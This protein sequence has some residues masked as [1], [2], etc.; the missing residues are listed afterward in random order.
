VID[1]HHYE[2]MC[3]DPGAHRP[4]LLAL[5][6][7]IAERYRDRPDR[8]FF[9][10]LNEPNGKLTDERW[11][12]LIPEL[13]R[14]VRASNPRRAVIV[15]PGSWNNLDHLDRLRLPE[16]DRRLIVTF[17]YYSPFEFTH[18][19][20]G[21][22]PGSRE[23]QGRTWTGTPGQQGALRKDF[24]RAAAWA[25]EHRRPLYVGEFGAYSAADTGSRARWTRALA[26]EAER[27][28]MSWA[29]W[30]FAAGF[31]AYD[32]RARA[33]RAPLLKGLL[34]RQP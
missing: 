31:G 24:A 6:R 28:G 23:W 27:H 25:R 32:P 33:W 4:R 1:V 17:H 20:A 26:R 3:R 21:W 14:V 30:E 8:L 18:Q 12:E 13:L 22:V 19:G 2:E 9:D 16:G 10:L 7:Q 11:Q 34:D 15:G 29:Y 5:W